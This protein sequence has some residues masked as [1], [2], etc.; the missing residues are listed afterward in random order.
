MGVPPAGNGGTRNSGS[1]G[2]NGGN[3]AGRALEAAA[4]GTGLAG[5]LTAAAGPGER[6]A[7]LDDAGLAGAVRRWA[8]EEAW[9]HGRM[10]AAIRP[11]PDSTAV[12]FTPAGPPPPGGYGDQDGYGTWNLRIADLDLT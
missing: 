9:C 3:A 10:L 1:Q 12:T 2:N 7:A 5:L 6:Y 11:R 8:D 4:T